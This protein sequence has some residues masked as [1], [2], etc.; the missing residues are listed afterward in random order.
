MSTTHDTERRGRP[1]PHRE[2]DLAPVVPARDG[3]RARHDRRRRRGLERGR[4]AQQPERAR[5]VAHRRRARPAG[6]RADRLVAPGQPR[7]HG[8]A[9]PRR[10]RARPGHA[11]GDA[12]DRGR[13]A[14]PRRWSR[15]RPRSST[16]TSSIS[17]FAVGSGSTRAAMGATNMRGAAAAARTALLKLASAQ[18]GVP[19]SSLSV[20]KGVVS[21]GGKTVKYADLMAGKL[22]Q[23]TI[24]AQSAT[25]TDPTQVQGDRHARAAHRHPGSSSPAARRSSRT[26]ACRG[27]STAAS[28][29]RAARAPST[30][31]R[32]CSAS[33]RARSSTSTGA[34]VVRHRQLRRRRRAE[35]VGRDP[36]RGAAQ[37]QVGRDAEA[38]RQRQPRRRR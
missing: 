29:A 17:A 23:S 32:S 18:L 5:R 9:L 35:G 6:R 10:R 21:G 36:G 30:R 3:P 1:R 27:C 34:Q 4:G 11:D 24:A 15:S 38:L 22:F 31:A 37:G 14:R 2:R 20:D 33:T 25:L 7:Q 16:P 13:G 19:V 26:C 12:A 8:H 28:S